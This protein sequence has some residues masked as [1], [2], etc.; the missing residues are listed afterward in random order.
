MYFDAIKDT[1]YCSPADDEHRQAARWTMSRVSSGI[2]CVADRQVL[3]S[4]IQMMAPIL[5]HLAEE[6]AAH[7]G[8]TQSTLLAGWR[9][10]VSRPV[11]DED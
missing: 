3:S 10:S 1:L 4:M 11:H 7:L 5:P 9:P 8:A 2:I 6:L